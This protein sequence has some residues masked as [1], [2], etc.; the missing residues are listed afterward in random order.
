MATN[1][2]EIV[3]FKM[4]YNRNQKIDIEVLKT[5]K[6]QLLLKHDKQSVCNAKKFYP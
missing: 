5:S 4:S 1:R 2:E 3:S 6:G